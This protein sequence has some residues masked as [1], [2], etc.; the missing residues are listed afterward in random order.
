MQYS[1]GSEE[2]G[3]RK[4]SLG[5]EIVKRKLRKPAERL[6]LSEEKQGIYRRNEDNNGGGEK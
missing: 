1:S 4:S 3:Q 5:G 2:E 6:S